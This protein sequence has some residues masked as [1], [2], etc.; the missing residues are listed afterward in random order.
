MVEN[1]TRVL[2][3]IFGSIVGIGV[4]V[5]GGTVT[6]GVAVSTMGPTVPVGVQ[7][8]GWKA[9]AVGEAFGAAVTNVN[10]KDCCVVGAADAK[11]PHPAR[12]YPARSV[13][14]ITFLIRYW[15]GGVVGVLVAVG[16]DV[17]RDVAVGVAVAVGISVAVGVSVAGTVVSVGVGVAVGNSG[18]TVTPGTGVRVGM[19]GTQ[20]RCPE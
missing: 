6:V 17:G 15:D 10:G 11:A 4:S 18:I 2:A 3:S 5:G 8:M 19:F 9:V 14:W 16:V 7:G 20:S 12:K 1:G 13:I